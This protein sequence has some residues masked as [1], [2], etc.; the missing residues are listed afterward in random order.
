MQGNS[1][2]FDEFTVKLTNLPQSCTHADIRSALCGF[3]RI[4]KHFIVKDTRMAIVTFEEAE[5]VR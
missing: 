5:P 2:R 1:N 4:K 3:G